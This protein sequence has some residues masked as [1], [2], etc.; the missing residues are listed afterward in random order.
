MY[1]NISSVE[2]I[3]DLEIKQELIDLEIENNQAGT[4]T[5]IAEQ[6]WYKKA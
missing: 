2:Y 3:E 6:Y 1:Y 4:I 5:N